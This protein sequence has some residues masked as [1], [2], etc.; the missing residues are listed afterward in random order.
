MQTQ[1]T[2]LT[3]CVTQVTECNRIPP[4]ST[5]CN[6]MQ[7]NASHKTQSNSHTSHILC[8]AQTPVSKSHCLNCGS[9]IY[10]VKI[11]I[12]FLFLKIWNT[13]WERRWSERL[14]QHCWKEWFVIFYRLQSLHVSWLTIHDLWLMIRGSCCSVILV[15]L[16]LAGDTFPATIQTQIYLDIKTFKKLARNMYTLEY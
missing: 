14:T 9:S 5:K 10:V 11:N 15:N 4:K 16:A 1:A 12:N 8:S 13:C 7:F 2:K 3:T 6:W